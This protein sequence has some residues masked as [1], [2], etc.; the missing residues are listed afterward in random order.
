MGDEKWTKNRTK[1]VKSRADS[2]KNAPKLSG[3]SKRVEKGRREVIASRWSFKTEPPRGA[4]VATKCQKHPSHSF[5]KVMSN[6]SK[7]A[8]FWPLKTLDRRDVLLFDTLCRKVANGDRLAG[9]HRKMANFG[10]KLA[11]FEI[12][13]VYC[14]QISK[15]ANSVHFWPWNPPE[16]INARWDLTP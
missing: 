8:D 2:S 3:I 1:K 7:I 15:M 13:T 12:S 16:R 11:I 10:T 14:R 6:G 4:R 5:P 9:P